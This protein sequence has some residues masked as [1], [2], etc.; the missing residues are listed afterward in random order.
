MSNAAK[1][2]EKPREIEARHFDGDQ[3]ALMDVVSWIQ[4][5]GYV[6]YD[7]FTPAPAGG[8]SMD[9][10]T[11]FLL[12]VDKKGELAQV[13]RGYWII[14]KPNGNLVPMSNAEFTA[15]YEVVDDS[16][17]IVAPIE[18]TPAP[19]DP[20]PT[21]EPTPAP[22]DPTPTPDPVEPVDPAQMPP[23]TASGVDK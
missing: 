17:V 1:F 22:V 23:T 18:P 15:T 11:G 8:V 14:K 20:T 13:Q 12:L 5:N 6:W 21:P 10:S 2:R 16:T 3:Q 4:E 19:E 7:M 9:P